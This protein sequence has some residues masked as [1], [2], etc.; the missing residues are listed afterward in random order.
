M[1]TNEMYNFEEWAADMDANY[2][3]GWTVENGEL[4]INWHGEWLLPYEI[5]DAFSDASEENW[6]DAD[7][8]TACGV[9][10][11]FTPYV[12]KNNDREDM[13]F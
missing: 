5:A 1:T 9:P 12:H 7:A 11:D 8:D 13:P 2:P 6:P 4:V 3:E 10:K